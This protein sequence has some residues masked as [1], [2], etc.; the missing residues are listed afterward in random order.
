MLNQWLNLEWERTQTSWAWRNKPPKPAKITE[1]EDLE[2]ARRVEY[3]EK[4]RMNSRWTKA[5]KWAVSFRKPKPVSREELD[6]AL[7]TAVERLVR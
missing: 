4:Q 6:R 7:E 1:K 5:A 2:L 3:N